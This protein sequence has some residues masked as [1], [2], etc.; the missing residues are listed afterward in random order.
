MHN[1]T[2]NLNIMIKAA[3]KASRSLIRDFNEIEKLQVVSKKAG[4]FVSKADLRA[5]KI[6]KE[7]LMS[8]R[9]SY[10][11]CAE[12]SDEIQGEDPT[13][14]WLVDPLD[15]TTNFL[16]GIPH[17]AISIALEHKQEIVAGIIYDPIKDELF[18]AQKG[19]GSWLNEQRLRVSNRTS[20][21]EMLF[22]T[23]IPFGESD[24]LEN[25]LTSIG[26]LVPS[27][28]GI[29]RNGAAS[30]DLAYVAA[31]RFDG[32]WEQNLA[33]WDIA[34]GILIVKEAGGI[35]E[36]IEENLNPIKTGNVICSN[37]QEEVFKKFSKIIRSS[38]Q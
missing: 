1:N 5:E 33:P 15:G 10:G 12:E 6:I 18:S 32:F 2:A 21:Q 30:L 25:S 4:D 16:H 23:G 22:A 20:F 36:S 26:N 37:N 31:G 34:S 9:A 38:V 8:A 11:W 35:L 14:R 24:Y 3:R 29:R 28:A 27:C 17:W 19:G 13:R 7:E